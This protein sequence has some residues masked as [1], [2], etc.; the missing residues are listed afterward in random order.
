MIES[1]LKENL[2]VN[3]TIDGNNCC[4]KHK[5]FFFKRH[6]ILACYMESMPPN[7]HIFLF[8]SDVMVG[9]PDVSLDHWKNGDFDVSFFERHF[10]G[11]VTAGAYRVKNTLMA[12]DFLRTWANYEFGRPPG[13]S[14]ADNGAIHV[15]LLQYFHLGGKCVEN[16]YNLMIQMYPYL[17]V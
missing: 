11:E 14:S 16:F 7:A 5:D 13:F 9:M 6:C 15:A 4:D 3:S 17:A 12:R 10:S 2:K 8:D 1:N